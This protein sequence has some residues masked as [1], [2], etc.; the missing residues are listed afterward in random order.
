[1]S[2]PGPGHGARVT[3]TG[4]RR[5]LLPFV[6]VMVVALLGLFER[7]WRHDEIFSPADLVY[8]FYPW[9][10]D[11]T[12]TPAANP[13]RSDEA[14]YH[15]PL[16]ASHFARLRDGALPDYDDSRLSGV[17]AFFNG[18]DVGRAFSPFS[19]PYYL[20]PSEDAVN[21]YGPLRLFVAALCMW[22]FLRELGLGDVGAAAGGV[23]YGLNGHFLTW[24]SAPMP[25]V[26]AWL[27]LVLR[28]VRRCVRY[29]RWPDIAGLALALGALFLGT[30]MAT[31]LVCLFGAGVYGLVELWVRWD[32][33]R[34]EGRDA[35][36]RRPRR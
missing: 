24:L 33:S 28:Q 23:A 9:A 15:Q 26:A 20:L 6:A 7:E 34:S 10:H 12:R 29:G 14:F 16:M 2:S 5:A 19:L 25:T 30:Y 35:S 13:T 31:T 8:Q 11:T 21:W 4:G 17:P 18:L 32:A 36:P 1:M 27:P 22:L 3:G